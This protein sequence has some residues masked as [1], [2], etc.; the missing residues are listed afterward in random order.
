MTRMIAVVGALLL[1]SWVLA[2]AANTEGG[3][4]EVIY[5]ASGFGVDIP[6]AADASKNIREVSIDELNID[7][8]EMT[9]GL[10]V[11]YRLYGP[12]AVHWGSAKF[13][14]ACTRRGSKE[15]QAWWSEAAKGKGIRKTIT[16]TLFKSDKSPGRTHTLV[17]ARPVDLSEC[18]W[19]GQEMVRTIT[20]RPRR[21]EF[22]SRKDAASPSKPPSGAWFRLEVGQPNGPLVP[23]DSWEMAV[24]GAKSHEDPPLV[25]GKLDPNDPN[26]SL[27]PHA[28]CT[29]LTLRGPMT[30]LRQWLTTRINDTTQG[31][32]WER[33]LYITP[34]G[35]GAYAFVNAF[36]IGYVFPRMSV[37]NTTGNTMEE[38]V[39][40]PIRC[41]LK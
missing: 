3:A 6:G 38:V 34:P 40:R 41:E 32:P 35:A 5:N 39:I 19:S 33:R 23:D 14:S 7:V 18:I 25:I 8:R 11:E 30:D 15:L 17:D 37:T 4:Y 16:V 2:S 21:I 10:D 26:G 31:N 28:T 27:A 12:G 29:D 20:V 36:P 22:G 9:T 24:G 13:T 1:G